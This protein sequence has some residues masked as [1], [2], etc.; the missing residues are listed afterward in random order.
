MVWLLNSQGMKN[1][2]DTESFC[3]RIVA[4]YTDDWSTFYMFTAAMFIFFLGIS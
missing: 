2:K 1:R 3:R 4:I